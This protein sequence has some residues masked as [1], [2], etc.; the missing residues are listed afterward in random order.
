MKWFWL[1]VTLWLPATVQAA[2]L[3]SPLAFTWQQHPGARVPLNSQLRDEH[4][5]PFRFGDALGRVPVILDLGYYHCPT[6]CG[7]VRAN[8]I[9][10]LR[11]SGLSA[12][13][14][15]LVSVSID[16][17]ETPADALQAKTT[18]L[19]QLGAPTPPNW[20][21]LTGTSGTVEAIATAVGF[22][23]EYSARYRQFLHPAGLTI[24]TGGGVVSSY[25]LGVG[26]SGGDLRTAVLRARGGVVAQAALPV[27]LLC[28]HYDPGT[29]HYTLAIIKL[30]RLMGIMTIV[31]IGG[32]LVLLHRHRRARHGVPA[33]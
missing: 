19:D 31:T 21:Y 1:V 5:Q 24:L 4:G 14:Y 8:L 32:L 13:D 29:G 22:R 16:P 2:S 27:L 18:D 28:F 17:A 26:Y 20:H 10:A 12:E 23:D 7:V 33:R 3:P 9:D 15:T 30:L 25:L 11:A 6:L